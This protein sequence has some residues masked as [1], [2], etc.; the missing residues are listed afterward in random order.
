MKKYIF[1]ILAIAASA[2]FT[3]G[4]DTAYKESKKMNF[5]PEK[6]AQII[7]T[8]KKVAHEIAPKI[9]IDTLVPL[10]F[11][12]F[13][14][15]NHPI[16]NKKAIA[17]HYMKHENDYLEMEL[18]PLDPVTKMPNGKMLTRKRPNSIL[19][20]VLFEDSLEPVYLSD[21][22]NRVLHFTPDYKTYRRNNPGRELEPFVPH[23]G[24]YIVY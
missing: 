20:V 15:D 17:V 19:C 7:Q 10:I 23:P 24:E 13:I 18:M 4:E 8:A 6:E 22:H 9:N 14:A 3:Y 2:F 16:I 12:F 1:L 11:S 21:S 5:K